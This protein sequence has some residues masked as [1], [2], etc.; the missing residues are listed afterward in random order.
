MFLLPDGVGLQLEVKEKQIREK[1]RRL[2]E[3]EE[4]PLEPIIGMEPEDNNGLGCFR[5]RNK[6]D[7]R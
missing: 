4:P 1:L 7:F 6:A 2:A 3:I 5:Y